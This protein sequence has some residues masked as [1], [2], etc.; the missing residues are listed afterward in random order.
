MAAMVFMTEDKRMRKCGKSSLK[1]GNSHKNVGRVSLNVVTL[2]KMWEPP[3]KNP[4]TFAL[5]ISKGE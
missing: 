5:I 4:R 1:C 2:A 3:R